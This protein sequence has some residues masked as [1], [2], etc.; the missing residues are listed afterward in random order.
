MKSSC[1]RGNYRDS[2]SKTET[3][4]S[5]ARLNV[6]RETLVL[7]IVLTAVGAGGTVFVLFSNKAA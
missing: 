4:E 3:L 7:S 6:M 5:V 1:V 2:I